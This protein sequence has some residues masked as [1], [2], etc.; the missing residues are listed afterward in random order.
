MS[1]SVSI[2]KKGR[3]VLPKKIRQEA[4]ISVGTKLIAKARGEGRVELLDPETLVNKAQEIGAKKLSGW[5]EDAHEATANL[6]NS[7]RKKKSDI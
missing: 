7:M 1:E 4:H 6:L 5:R 2:D 3:L